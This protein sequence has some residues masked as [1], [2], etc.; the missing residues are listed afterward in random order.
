MNNLCGEMKVCINT[1]DIP[2]VLYALCHLNNHF[3]G[4]L[5]HVYMLLM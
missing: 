1:Q 5:G 4:E 2:T 3:V